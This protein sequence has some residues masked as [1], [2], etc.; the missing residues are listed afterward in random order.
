MT[1]LERLLARQLELEQEETLALRLEVV[2][3]TRSIEATCTERDCA[4]AL[5]GEAMD[6]L[7]EAGLDL[8]G[9]TRP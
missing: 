7:L 8:P 9:E 5:L 3:L 2:A 1:G 4:D 6:A